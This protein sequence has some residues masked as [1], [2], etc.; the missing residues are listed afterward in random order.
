MTSSTYQQLL[1]ARDFYKS[2]FPKA[3]PLSVI[4][5]GSGLGPVADD[6]KI[7]SK[8]SF[9]DL[10][11]LSSP[12]VEG[13]NGEILLAELSNGTQVLFLKGRLHAYEGHNFDK[14]LFAV[15][16]AHL[17]GCKNFV[18]TNAAGSINLDFKPGDLVLIK[19]HINMSGKNPLEGKNIDELGPRFPDMTVAYNLD[20]RQKMKTIATQ[21]KI[22]LKEGVYG[23]VMGPCYETPAEIKML[24]IVGADMVGMSTA[25]DVIAARHV[26]MNVVGIS[27]ITNFG[28]GI[29]NHLLKHDDVK[30]EAAKTMSKMK[31]LINEFLVSSLVS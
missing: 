29:T 30:I 3:N 17:M 13:H 4:V 22:D 24:R 19:D 31:L 12:S 26:G 23:Y 16:W 25:P 11:Y 21:H 2:S 5:L 15:R 27:C 7:L 1:E 10:P 9:A 20:F 14:V 6:H 18:V 28:A 8:I